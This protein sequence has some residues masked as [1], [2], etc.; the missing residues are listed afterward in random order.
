MGRNEIDSWCF[1][2]FYFGVIQSAYA[3]ASEDTPTP[4]IVFRRQS[5]SGLPPEAEGVGWRRG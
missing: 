3:K 4:K 2:A 5:P 1:H